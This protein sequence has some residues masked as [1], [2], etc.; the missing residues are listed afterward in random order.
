MRQH[1]RGR[2]TLKSGNYLD[3]DGFEDVRL[4]L[5]AN[6]G[7]SNDVVMPKSLGGVISI[8]TIWRSHSRSVRVDHRIGQP[9]NAPLDVNGFTRKR[10]NAGCQQT[11]DE[12]TGHDVSFP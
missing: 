2:T 4:R 11:V 8:C 6:V 3:Q 12:I 9:R 10:W 7:S 5:A 1:S